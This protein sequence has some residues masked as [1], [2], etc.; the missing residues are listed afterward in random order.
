MSE[1]FNHCTHPQQYVLLGNIGYGFYN[2]NIKGSWL[3]LQYAEADL[4]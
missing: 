1:T 2:F 4:T 3:H